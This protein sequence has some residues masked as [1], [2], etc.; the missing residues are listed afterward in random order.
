MQDI[1][2]QKKKKKKGIVPILTFY[3]SFSMG[4]IRFTMY[5]SQP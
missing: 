2:S 4:K 1:D 3:D 5:K